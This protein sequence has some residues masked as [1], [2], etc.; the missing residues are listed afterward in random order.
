MSAVAAA[1]AVAVTLVALLAP[2]GAEAV[3]AL[4]SGFQ[5]SIALS[6]L[7]NPTT[8]Q[9]SKDGRIFVA[10]QSGL[11][12]VFD[13][14]SDTTPTT[15]ADLR[16][17]V[18][19]YWDSGMLGLALDPNFP[20]KPYVYAL[21][22]HDAP[23]G[24]TA[25]RWG[26]AC[27]SPPDPTKD[28]CV[29][30]GRLSR[31]QADPT[32]GTM[33][34]SEQVLIEDWCQQYPSHSVGS[35]V[36]GPDGA[37]YVSHG[38]GA[39]WIFADYGQGGGSN[40]SPTP[41]NPCGDP[42]GGVGATLTPPTA[43]GGA[44]RSQDLRT[45]GDPVGLDGTILRVDPATGNALP[46]NPLI[47]NTDPNA[48]RVVAY[49]L[50]NPFRFTFKPG[51]N[52][53]WLG[54]VGWNVTE[55][56]DRITN[57]SDSTV[58]DFGWPCYEGAG[59]QP[60]YDSAN[61]N[62]C[63]NLYAQANA[64]KSPYFS[65]EHGAQVAG[66]SCP[67]NNGSV[68]SAMAF[69]KGG[70]YPDEYD[71]ALFFAD[72][73]RRCIWVMPKGADGLPNPGQVRPFVTDAENP[74]DLQVGPNGDLFYVDLNGGTIRRIKYAA[75]NQPPEARATANPTN[76][77]T[78][79]TVN[80]DGT[81][82]SDAEGTTLTYEWD[83]DGDGAYDDS[84]SPQPTYTYTTA[85]SYQVGLKVT[86]G[87]GASD[88]LDQ[89]LI[90]SAGNTAPSATI[91][92]PLPTTTWK[93]GDT[94]SFSGSATD[95][96]DGALG[97]SNLSWSLIMHHCTTPNACHE[98]R[99]QD[100]A[101][102][103]SG[104]FVAPDHEYPSY[105][106]LRLIATD[107]GGLTDTRSVRL[108]PKTVELTFGSDPAGLQLTVGSS[109]GTTPFTR[110]VIAGSKNSV[111]TPS[112]QTL[113]GTNYEF[114]SWSDGG[115]QSHDIVAPDT[116]TTYTANYRQ[117]APTVTQSFTSVADGGLS[118]LSP[119]A[120]SG[121][122]RTLKV[123]GDDPDPGG[124]DLYAALRWD[125]SQI[126]A[127]ATVGSATVTL[128]ISNHANDTG[129]PQTYGAYELK[130]S[131][132]ENQMT[133][134]QAA[135]GAPWA[136]AGAKATTDRGPKIAD[137]TPTAKAP[138]T[139]TI[140]ASVVQGWLS[141]PS[142]NN[143]ILLADPTNF[144]GFVFDTREGTTPPK[145]TVNYTTGSQ[146]TT[147]PE[148]TID[149]GPSGTFTNPSASFTFSSSEANSTFE[150]SLDGANF[151]SCTSPKSYAGLSDGSH[152][153]SVRAKDAAGNVDLTPAT[154]TWTIN[155]SSQS[156]PVLVG[157]GDIASCQSSGDEATAKLLDGISGTVF[158][159]GDNA[160]EN[161]SAADFASC[162]D[163]SWGR[164]KARTRPAVGNHEYQTPN[165]S[166][167][168]GYFG[169]AAGDPDKGYYSYDL[170]GWHIISL[171]SMCENVGGCGE[172]SPMVTW[173]K[174]DLATNP[175]ACTAAYFHHPLF[176]SGSEYGNDPKMKPSW[177]A[178]YAAGAEVVLNGHEH[179]YERFA[180]QT[181]AGATDTVQG[182]REF[183]VGMGGAEHYSFGTIQPN[184]QVR[185]ADTYGVLKL[186]LHSGSYDWQF[187][188]EA[189]KT[190]TDSGTD[191]CHGAPA[192]TDTTAP[193]TVSVV[194]NEGATGVAT[195]ANVEATFSEAMDAP[196]IGG[197]TFTLTKLGSTQ[198]V[199]AQVSY[200]A[201]SK[202]AI[203]DPTAVLDP[204]AAYSATIKG[205]A[206]GVKDLAGNPLETDKTWSFGTA[207]SPPP[208]DT[209]PPETTID[210]GPSG[211]VGSS[212]A[213]FAFSSSEANST[214]EC[215][216]DGASF[217]SCTSPRSYTSLSDGSHTFSVRATDTAGNVDGTP[218]TRTWTVN[219]APASQTVNLNSV[220]DAG[221]SEL[222]PTANSGTA[223]TLKVD[224]DDPDPGGK[225]LYAALRWDL[226]QVPAG[227][228]V[229]SATVT[230]S[231]TN[232]SND[233]GTPQTYGAYELKRTWS[234][235]QMTWNQAATGA[236]WATAGAKATTDR[237]PKIAS[238]TPTALGSYTFTI[239]ASVVQG[240]LSAPS[241][242]NGILL[243]DPTNFDGF[244]FRTKEGT[245]PPK[246]TVNYTTA[247]GG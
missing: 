125:L 243:A 186:T 230:L 106:E 83:L 100:F 10:E 143:G 42:P 117:A 34:G 119:T 190:F 19:N 184:S 225:D 60:G 198:Q 172:S 5:D 169:S 20:S 200:D 157:A 130:R 207:A 132:S 115:A 221:L 101:G 79:L 242:N 105:L 13:N 74:V 237:G 236:P 95:P 27:P 1:V 65:Y 128:N 86:D 228:T 9:F 233:T 179:V 159:T 103:S 38:D 158:T 161:G 109:S 85:G 216:L 170:G 55:E 12:K 64:V 127:G 122:A 104:S 98:H 181:P 215:K 124:K 135:T 96:Q 144:D 191:Q 244:V 80:F 84:T 58:E 3:P 7:T 222:S 77:S 14:L 219:T 88:T 43:E 185:N 110:T 63:E 212:S 246:L 73:S 171:N 154:R 69:Y 32:T 50:R 90:I 145:L 99:V 36:F 67:T 35:L 52:E 217:G 126:P 72:H 51:T 194:P 189:G 142:T 28:G 120:N 4:P 2:S 238:V 18:Y 183:N 229:S 133:W 108:D 48:R 232:H 92:T 147:P 81:T 33:T 239:P 129:T 234:E 107:S 44:L 114:V 241:T 240:W 111:S 149:S 138:Y 205:G 187:V 94:I 71:D 113:G 163:S 174:N 6:G 162:Y 56:V 136:T 22:T 188:P 21:Y 40:G 116:S 26:D 173:L 23:I 57:P 227:A 220:A 46:D 180:P 197:S 210:S 151:A 66:E 30:S 218:A 245:S 137:V 68:I 208:L 37:L 224:G 118:E 226:S 102:V 97:A 11:I 75:A 235:N 178:L 223:T 61:L 91:D 153:F 87:Q 150:C 49:G 15:F 41:K 59:R 204:S 165:A 192:N 167:Y 231:I 140:P 168:F 201:A 93:V 47:G 31:L 45:A 89:P 146:D 112:P 199:A 166:G 78:P 54:D 211:T 82:S 134:N 177:D 29:V 175:K 123:D 70:P 152:T 160:Y 121:T 195:T 16:S 196:T 62:I 131:W 148:T 25:P 24:G 214:F 209:T 182:I 247:G 202:K 8:G 141:A 53:L 213:S 203:L 176:N 206:S 156:D 76:G 17:K 193:T 139:F 39:S 155:T 164:H